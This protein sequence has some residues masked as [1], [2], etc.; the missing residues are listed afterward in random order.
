MHKTSFSSKKSTGFNC[1]VSDIFFS[2]SSFQ[3]SIHGLIMSYL[4]EFGKDKAC[5]ANQLK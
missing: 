1:L 4:R 2:S 5:P 3:G